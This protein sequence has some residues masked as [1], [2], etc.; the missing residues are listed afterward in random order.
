MKGDG[1]RQQDVWIMLF[2][3]IQVSLEAIQREFSTLKEISSHHKKRSAEILNLLVRDLSEIGSVLG[4]TE[5]RAVRLN[6][7]LLITPG[8]GHC[9]SEMALISPVSIFRW[10]QVGRWRKSSPQLASMSAR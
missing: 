5:L 9:S 4:I 10:R 7:C 2:P 8:R 1:R 6:L 3:S